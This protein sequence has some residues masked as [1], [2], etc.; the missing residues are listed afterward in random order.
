MLDQFAFAS[1]RSLRRRGSAAFHSV[2]ILGVDVSQVSFFTTP[3]RNATRALFLLPSQSVLYKHV[4]EGFQIIYF[5]PGL[6]PNKRF[7]FP[8]GCIWCP[9]DEIRA[10]GTHLQN[11]DSQWCQRVPTHHLQGGDRTLLL[12]EAF[13][14]KRKG[15]S[16]T[17]ARKRH[18]DFWTS[19][20]SG[21]QVSPLKVP[22]FAGLQE[23]ECKSYSRLTDLQPLQCIA[24]LRAGKFCSSAS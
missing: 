14:P 19:N 1:T 15:R 10:I 9:K 6:A 20:H 7:S 11:S 22:G 13:K 5:L 2:F 24:G 3:L 16:M 18:L 23:A 21:L 12:Y 8:L 4:I 17:S